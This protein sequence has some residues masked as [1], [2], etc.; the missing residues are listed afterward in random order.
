MTYAMIDA[1]CASYPRPPV[2]VTL[3][4][5]DTVD[6]VHGHQQLS[7]F[8]AHY[9]ERCFLPTAAPRGC[10]RRRSGR[11]ARLDLQLPRTR[12]TFGSAASGRMDR[13]RPRNLHRLSA[14]GRTGR[15]WLG[16]GHRKPDL[17][18]A[19]RRRVCP[20]RARSTG[21]RLRGALAVV[22]RRG[23]HRPG[24]V[25]AAEGARHRGRRAHI[26]DMAG[27]R[28]PARAYG[29]PRRRHRARSAGRARETS[30]PHPRTP[31]AAAASDIPI[32]RPPW[33]W[34]KTCA[35]ATCARPRESLGR[36]GP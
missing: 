33:R 34:R 27:G 13:R 5:D 2:A 3:D 12:R 25:A 21:S 30:A 35:C 31:R 15:L 11:H 18:G 20:Q 28:R 1:Y 9:D 10:D 23:G 7:L 36:C 26:A 16:D 17:R 14:D 6:V 19:Q 22:R 24:R 29:E 8:N 4:I 32:P